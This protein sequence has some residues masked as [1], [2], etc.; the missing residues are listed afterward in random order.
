MGEPLWFLPRKWVQRWRV[1][2]VV[3]GSQVRVSGGTRNVT[4]VSLWYSPSLH[5][6][7]WTALDLDYDRF[8]PHP[9][10]LI[11]EELSYRLTLCSR[12]TG[13]TNFPK[14]SSHHNILS[15]Q[16]LARSTFHFGD[17]N[18]LGIPPYKIQSFGTHAVLVRASNSVDE[19]INNRIHY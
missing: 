19:W 1:W 3:R 7:A 18:T 10:Q 2:H 9:L 17:P 15:A 16:R 5:G 11:S 12:G 14:T 8:L 13:F 6:Y 4:S